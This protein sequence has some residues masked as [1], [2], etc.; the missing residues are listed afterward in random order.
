[1]Q[2]AEPVVSLYVLTPHNWQDVP[3]P[4]APAWPA[5]KQRNASQQTYK[6]HEAEQTRVKRTEA[7]CVVQEVEKSELR[8][9]TQSR[10]NRVTHVQKHWAELVEPV[11]AV[12]A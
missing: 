2:D 6:R 7:P 9:V 11:E 10:Q 1:M 12:L 5:G 3:G 4:V 8:A